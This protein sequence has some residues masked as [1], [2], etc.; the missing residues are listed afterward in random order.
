MNVKIVQAVCIV[1]VVQIK[2]ISKIWLIIYNIKMN[3][4]H[5]KH[6]F[7]NSEAKYYFLYVYFYGS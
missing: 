1:T 2:N 6:I 3:K 4:K 5:R 7:K